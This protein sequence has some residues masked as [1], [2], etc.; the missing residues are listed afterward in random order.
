MVLLSLVAEVEEVEEV[1]GDTE[2]G[3]SLRATS[4]EKVWCISGSAQ[5]KPVLLKGQLYI[6]YVKQHVLNTPTATR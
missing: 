2:E 4:T 3:G 1:D 6:L 5:V